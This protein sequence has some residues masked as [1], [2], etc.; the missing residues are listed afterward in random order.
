[1]KRNSKKLAFLTAAICVVLCG[2]M[3]LGGTYAWF[4]DEVKTGENVIKSG[5]LDVTFEYE[6]GTDNWVDA[7]DK[8]I[9]NYEYWEPG[10]AVV[11]KVKIANV[12]DLA[13]KYALKLKTNE[14]AND[15]V[16]LSD[17]IDVYMSTTAI[18]SRDDLSPAICVGTL[19]DLIADADGAAKGNMKPDDSVIVYIALKMQESAGNEYQGLSIG[20]GIDVQLIAEQDTVESDDFGSDYDDVSGMPVAKVT[21]FDVPE[22]KMYIVSDITQGF[23][24]ENIEIKPET[25]F[26]F[27][28]Q[29]DAA[30]VAESP[31]K[32]WLVDFYVSVNEPIEDGIALIGCYGNWE[33]GAWYG[34]NAPAGDYSDAVPLLGTMTGGV[35]NWTYEGIVTGVQ[36]FNCGVASYNDVNDGLVMTVELRMMNPDDP[37]EYH[38][39][40]S[41]KHTFKHV[42]DS[43]TS[44]TV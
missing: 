26:T 19:A 13:F 36:E 41:V 14:V 30:S 28:A 32:D 4:N 35:S 9:F 3:I 34:F 21:Y 23:G 5:K 24:G 44:G 42:E 12:G 37:T 27:V 17:V 1:M 6:D 38:V 18:T 20:D 10:Y 15:G 22:Q 39:L 8:T 7:S 2:A 29:D 25:A 16:K 33:S 11:R 43:V 31:Y 40:K